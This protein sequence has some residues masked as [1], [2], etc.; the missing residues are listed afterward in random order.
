MHW[1]LKSQISF[2]RLFYILLGWSWIIRTET[3][4]TC[5]K[6]V[7]GGWG[8]NLGLETQPWGKGRWGGALRTFNP[9]SPVVCLPCTSIC[10][11]EPCWLTLQGCTQQLISEPD[12]RFA[13]FTVQS[14]ASFS[15][16]HNLI[17]LWKGKELCSPRRGISPSAMP[18]LSVCIKIVIICIHS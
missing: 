4:H 14:L 3:K 2:K 7:R 11:G 12:S 18:G 5:I 13:E 6:R 8:F 16:I 9:H 10:Q 17:F 15:N 1:M